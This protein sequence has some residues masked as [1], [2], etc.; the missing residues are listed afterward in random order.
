MN[1]SKEPPSVPSLWC[2]T[3]HLEQ[4][5][6]WGLS[7]SMMRQSLVPCSRTVEH[8]QSARALQN[9]A[10]MKSVGSS[11]PL[12][13][14]VVLEFRDSSRILLS[15]TTKYGFKAADSWVTLPFFGSAIETRT[16]SSEKNQGL[17][18]AGS[19]GSRMFWRAVQGIICQGEDL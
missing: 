19:L 18:A 11:M 9:T 15:R 12:T 4:S 1:V 2:S 5:A 17:H 8:V 14:E 10:A 6:S 13:L 7:R 3:W 16:C